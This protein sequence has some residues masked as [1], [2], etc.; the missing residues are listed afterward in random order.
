MRSLRREVLAM[1]DMSTLIEQNPDFPRPT[2]NTPSDAGSRA[3][4][5]LPREEKDDVFIRFD[6]HV[7]LST[8]ERAEKEI[9]RIMDFFPDADWKANIIEPGS[10]PNTYDSSYYVMSAMWMGT[11][12]EITAHR[13]VLCE[14][15]VIEEIEEEIEVPDPEI[16]KEAT[17]DVPMVKE[18]VTRSVSEWQCNKTLS[19]AVD[20]IARRR[21]E[22]A[23]NEI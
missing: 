12:L 14:R 18:T 17:K 8:K 10:S 23:S 3:Y 16:M 21:K 2:I 22:M 6:W 5:E 1:R 15:V 20:P 4:S 11:V 13:E 9:L 19:F 7:W